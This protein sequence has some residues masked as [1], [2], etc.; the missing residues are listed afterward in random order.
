M[1]APF[2]VIDGYN[3]MH[4]AGMA[5]AAYGRGELAKI[6]HELLFR[7]AKRLTIEE[8]QRCTVVF[9]AIDAPSNLPGRSVYQ[10]MTVLFAKPGHEADEL[11]ELL[12]AKHPAPRRL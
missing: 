9:D 6:R 11:I 5:R 3:V 10:G 2:L 4:A 12:I 1:S 7:L 8:R